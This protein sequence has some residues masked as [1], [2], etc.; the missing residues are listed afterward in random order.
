MKISIKAFSVRFKYRPSLLQILYMKL[1]NI[2][3]KVQFQI[4]LQ[5]ERNLNTKR[6]KQTK[7]RANSHKLSHDLF[8]F[9][10]YNDNIY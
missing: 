2:Y 7:H 10:G 8:N 5:M 6:N 9:H 4:K 3:S 1:L